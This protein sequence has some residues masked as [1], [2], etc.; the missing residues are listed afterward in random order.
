MATPN[1]SVTVDGMQLA[2][3]D[4]QDALAQVNGAYQAMSEQQATLA[5][6][7]SGEA[8]S[9][10]GTALATYLDDLQVVQS[11]LALILEKLSTQTGVYANTHQQSLET[12]QTLVRAVG[13]PLPGL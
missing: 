3:Q 9:S 12:A 4:F 11:Q 8:A 1:T 7:W 13:S 10:F 6:N 2:Q 5:A